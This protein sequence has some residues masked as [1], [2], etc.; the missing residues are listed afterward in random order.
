MSG[1]YEVTAV[2]EDNREGT[3]KVAAFVRDPFLACD[4]IVAEL[5]EGDPQYSEQ[6]V[7]ENWALLFCSVRR[8]D[9]C[10]EPPKA[11]YDPMPLGPK[12]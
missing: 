1:L 7:K 6:I 11:I 8:L 4:A 2:V 12:G 3:M 9:E 5:Q 10:E